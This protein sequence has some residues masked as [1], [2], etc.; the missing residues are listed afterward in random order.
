MDGWPV[1]QNPVWPNASEGVLHATWPVE[2]TH[3]S[4]VRAVRYG[5]PLPLKDLEKVSFILDEIIES[6]TV[7]ALRKAVSSIGESAR[8]AA[9][10]SRLYRRAMSSIKPGSPI[11]QMGSGNLRLTAVGKR[12]APM[13]MTLCCRAPTI[14]A[15]ATTSKPVMTTTA[16]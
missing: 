5:Y 7:H 16:A 12:K 15:L 6:R 3:N 9:V 1:L 11:G 2:F 13:V 10:R 8:M 4:I 14:A